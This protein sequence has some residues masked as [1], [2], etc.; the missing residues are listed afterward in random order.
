MPHSS[1]QRMS[2]VWSLGGLDER[3]V[4]DVGV[5]IGLDAEL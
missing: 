2:K 1:A 4:V 3:D 5:R